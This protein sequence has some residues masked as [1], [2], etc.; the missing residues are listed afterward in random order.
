MRRFHITLYTE[1]YVR[2]LAVISASDLDQAIEASRAQ[3]AMVREYLDLNGMDPATSGLFLTS[4]GGT[5]PCMLQF[6]RALPE[7]DV[8]ISIK[9]GSAQR[10]ASMKPVWRSKFNPKSRSQKRSKTPYTA[11]LQR[12]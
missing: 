7:Q 9:F 1:E 8:Q 4:V 11:L 2:P 10:A 5:A 12:S 3:M 6:A